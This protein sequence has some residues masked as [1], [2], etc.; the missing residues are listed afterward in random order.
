MW[1]RR[2]RRQ[3]HS[4]SPGAQAVADWLTLAGAVGLFAALFLTWSHQLPRGVLAAAGG[5]PALRG[6]P[7]DPTAWQVYSI[8]DVLLALLAA[9]LLAAALVGGSWRIRAGL[10]AAAGLALAFT[11]HAVSVPPTN[12]VLLINPASSPPACLPSAPTAGAGETVASVSLA[13]AAAGLGL[14]LA[15]GGGR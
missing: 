10:L 1:R 3:A 4:G 14:S 8:A 2:G 7:R 6:V 15:A 5:S 12:G 11:L 9:G 13:V